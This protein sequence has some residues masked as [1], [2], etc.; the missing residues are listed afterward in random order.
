MR[1][2]GLL[3]GPRRPSSLGGKVIVA[4]FEVA[5]VARIAL[6]EDAVGALLGLWEAI[7]AADRVA[8]RPAS[9]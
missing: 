1:S 4:P 3:R 2:D 7:D 5:G 9:R 6:I 8:L